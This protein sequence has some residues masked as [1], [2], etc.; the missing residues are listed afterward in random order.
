MATAS[1]RGGLGV[2]ASAGPE[3]SVVCPVFR[4]A[5]TLGQLVKQLGAAAPVSHELILVVDG[6][7]EGSAAEAWR[8]AGREARVAV[9]ELATNHGQTAAAVVGLCAATAPVRVVMDADLQDPPEA[10][11]ALLKL[12]AD[13]HDAVFA[14]RVGRYEGLGRTMTSWLF[15]RLLA[16]ISRVPTRAGAYVALT[17]QTATNV[18]GRGHPG[19]QTLPAIICRE[20]TAIGMHPVAR[21]ARSVG[22]SAYSTRRR[23]WVAAETLLAALRDRAGHRPAVRPLPEPL[24]WAAPRQWSAPSVR[25]D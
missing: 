7:P 15:K 17:A 16:A 24:R 21:R 13:G 11:A 23:A 10:I 6:C 5:E 14:T 18:I 8:L 4:N 12:V 2:R 22:R 19:R 25:E 20:A 3:L 9:A 1:H